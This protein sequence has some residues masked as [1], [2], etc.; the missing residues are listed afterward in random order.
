[1]LQL[2]KFLRFAAAFILPPFFGST[3][4]VCVI[5]EKRIAKLLCYSVFSDFFLLLCGEAN[6]VALEA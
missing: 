4:L 2:I 1:M 5:N 3:F 6:A